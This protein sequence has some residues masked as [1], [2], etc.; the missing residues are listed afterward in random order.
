MKIDK[1]QLVKVIDFW[2][3]SAR[4][5]KLFERA[6]LSAVDFKSKEIVDLV[7][8]RR[9]GKSSVLKLMIKKLKLKDDFLYLN[10]EDP[11]FIENNNPQIIEDSVD[12]YR[13]YFN[14]N[15]KYLFLDEIQEIKN[16]EKAVRKL[17]D[18]GSFK[19]FI[20][21][22]SSKLLSHE[23]SSLITGRHLSYRIFPLSFAEFLNFEGL[24]ISA[25]KDIILKEKLLQKKFGEYL[26]WGGFPEAVLQ[27][28]HELLKNYFLDILEKDIMARYEVRDRAM[29]EKMAVFLL[30][31]SAKIVTMEA[32][33]NNFNLSFETVSAYLEYFKD[34]FL[35]FDLPQFSFSLKKQQKAF[36][37]FYAIDIG[38]AK[39]ASFK[40]S[41]D[42]GRVLENAVFLELKLKR[43]G[44]YYYKTKNGLEVDFFSRENGK[45]KELIQ[46]S[47]S[48]EDESV[49]ER[50]IK[51]LFSAM[52]ELKMK[53]GTVLTYGESDTIK[54]D[55]KEITVEP[56]FRWMLEKSI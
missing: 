33:K 40:F 34:A 26:E 32:L 27:K 13:E 15:I 43:D 29:L 52:E 18:E 30:T 23:L 44:L 1:E 17:R 4:K 41:E 31:N 5:N 7:G 48:I 22:S 51:S 8:P 47:W 10:F 12:V 6:V 45:N 46:V 38:L 55:G 36:K 42:R 3:K 21:G 50:E 56:V 20:T 24:K 53:K 35:I 39:N 2:Q 14:A 28:N 19:I 11:F 16:W 25:K 37:K 54:K 49:R 9:S